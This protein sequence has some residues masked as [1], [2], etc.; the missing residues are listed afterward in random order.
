MIARIDT[1]R[2]TPLVLVPGIQGRCEWM[3]PT[4]DA[5]SSSFRVLS[6][7]LA[8]ER[9]SGH[10]LERRLGFDSFVVQ[11]DRMLEEADVADAILCGVSYGGLIALRYASL[12]PARVRQLVLVSALAP[13]YTPDARVRRYS[14]APR[15]F[16][17]V[18]C[19]GAWRHSRDE[20]QAALP[21][22]R[23]RAGFRVRQVWMVASAPV[24][25]VLMRDR[26]RML[27]GIDFTASART[28]SAPALVVTGE[29]GLDHVVPVAHT[30]AYADLLPQAD[31]VQLP[32]T[33]HLGVVTRPRA[34]AAIVSDFVTRAERGAR[35]RR[36]HEAAG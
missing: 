17:P 10:A 23:R 36:A 20:V 5:L 34:F 1:G 21:S 15:L 28:V 22:W 11:I 35:W 2:G 16:A 18:F 9:T 33:G 19:V 12:R 26:I 32:R 25:P 7:T 30:R 8:G 29:P 3:R 14:R 13:G 27:E 6:F 31:L 24:S 4:A